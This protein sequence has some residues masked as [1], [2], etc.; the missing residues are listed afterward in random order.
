MVFFA[1]FLTTTLVKVVVLSQN[2]CAHDYHKNNLT[3]TGD[4]NT[5]RK[6]ACRKAWQM[7][8][9]RAKEII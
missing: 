1:Q 5:P 4:L 6:V 3:S 2:P 7:Q 9:T 8:I